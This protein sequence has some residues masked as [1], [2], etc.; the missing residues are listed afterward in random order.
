M[1]RRIAHRALDQYQALVEQAQKQPWAT[2]DRRATMKAVNGNLRM[3]NFYLLE[4]LP[5]IAPITGTSL[6]YHADA[7]PRV[8]RALDLLKSWSDMVVSNEDEDAVAQPLL[9][10]V[11]MDWLVSGSIWELW[12][13]DKYRQ[14]V[15]EAATRLNAFTQ[16]R[17]G[18]HDASDSD[19]MAQAFSDKE[20]ERGKPRLRCPGDH[21]KM[22][23]Q[24]M[25]RGAML[26]SMG[27][28]QAIRNPAAHLTGDW[29]PVTAAEYLAALSIVARWVRHWDVV[30]YVPPPPDLNAI[31]AQ[32]KKD[33][34]RIG[35][36]VS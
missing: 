21:T 33:A 19:L 31:M 8:R 9:P 2:K 10:F 27:A 3:V 16:D 13:A 14:A 15:N 29:N 20:P 36:V 25:Q 34:D 23:V 4:L 1:N 7:L 17:L 32:Y 26:M 24:S 11:S 12:Q 22:T 18:R 35:R 28:F 6:S 30:R 5:D